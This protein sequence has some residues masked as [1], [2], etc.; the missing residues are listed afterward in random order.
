VYAE[1][2]VGSGVNDDVRHVE[3]LILNNNSHIIK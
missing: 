3:V 1:R 2:A